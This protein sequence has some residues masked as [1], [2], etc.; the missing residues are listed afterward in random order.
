ML[1]KCKFILIKDFHKY[2]Q[3]IY[4]LKTLV[5]PMTLSLGV[6]SSNILNID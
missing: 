4:G 2:E 3:K 5:V 1:E 6:T